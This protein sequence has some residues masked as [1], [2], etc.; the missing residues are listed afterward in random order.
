MS[1]DIGE[2]YDA[3]AGHPDVVRDLRQRIAATLKTFPQEIQKANADLL[4]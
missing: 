2:S 1:T 4:K 3:A